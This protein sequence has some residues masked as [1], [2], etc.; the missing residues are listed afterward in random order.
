M[1]Y[2]PCYGLVTRADPG[3]LKGGARKGVRGLPPENFLSI[4]F[5]FSIL[6]FTPLNGKLQF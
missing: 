4:E 5:L 1:Q 3:I 6:F 2:P